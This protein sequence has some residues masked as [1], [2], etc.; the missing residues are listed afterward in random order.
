MRSELGIQLEDKKF[1]NGLQSLSR[2]HLV[3]VWFNHWL[4]LHPNLFSH[5]AFHSCICLFISFYF[6]NSI[7][8]LL[9]HTLVHTYIVH[10]YTCTCTRT[11]TPTHTLLCIHTLYTHIHVHVLTPTHI[12][13]LSF[14]YIHCTLI[15]T[16]YMYMYSHTLLCIHT[17]YTHIHRMYMYSHTHTHP[18]THT[19]MHTYIVHSYTCIY[20]HCSV[21]THTHTQNLLSRSWGV[22]TLI[23]S[24]WWTTRKLQKQIHYIYTCDYLLIKNGIDELNPNTVKEVHVHT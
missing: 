16:M 5:P 14:A 24:K 23:P 1:R 19:L 18:H 15:Y 8:L 22:T 7:F 20:V 6:L 12:H 3:S 13:T 10:S 21:H 4:K 17:L 2:Q 11:H 9:T